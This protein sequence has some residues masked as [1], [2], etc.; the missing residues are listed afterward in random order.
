MF[1]KENEDWYETVLQEMKKWNQYYLWEFWESASQDEKKWSKESLYEILIE[2]WQ[3]VQENHKHKKHEKI[4][5]WKEC[6]DN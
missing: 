6:T 4:F 5:S 1:T 3:W 2:R